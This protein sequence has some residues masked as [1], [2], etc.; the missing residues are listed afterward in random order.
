M[1]MQMSDKLGRKKFGQK[2]NDAM[3]EPDNF[4]TMVPKWKEEQSKTVRKHSGN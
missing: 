2:G 1:M 4:M 3:K